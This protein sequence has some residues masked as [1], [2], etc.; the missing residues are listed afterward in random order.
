M[1]REHRPKTTESPDSTQAEPARKG[2]AVRCMPNSPEAAA[3][4]AQDW[5]QD[6]AFADGI[7][8]RAPEL[9]E[10]WE[11]R[12]EIETRRIP[13]SVIQNLNLE[14]HLPGPSA[15]STLKALSWRRPLQCR[16]VA[17]IWRENEVEDLAAGIV[18]P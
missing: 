5:L 16:Q 9:P 17:Q 8:G 6:S 2:H 11:P 4:W 10:W 12:S 13:R 14:P 1:V 3:A 7:D 18:T 15:H